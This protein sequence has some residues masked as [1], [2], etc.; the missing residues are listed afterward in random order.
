MSDFKH[1]LTSE[2]WE[3]HRKLR[4]GGGPLWA[5][6]QGYLDHAV[7]AICL[8]GKPYGFTREDVEMLEF[9]SKECDCTSFDNGLPH[10][11][12]DKWRDLAARIAALLPEK[13]L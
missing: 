12:G 4:F 1:A 6:Y 8:K 9:R 5:L 11:E 3:E 10:T 13:G 2:E 7:A